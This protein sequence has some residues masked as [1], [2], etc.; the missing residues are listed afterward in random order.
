M[1]AALLRGPGRPEQ[2]EIAEIPGPVAGPGEVLVRIE[3]ISVEG[4]D[5]V[6]RRTAGSF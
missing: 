5:L 1:K 2:C 6:A 3:A 4:G